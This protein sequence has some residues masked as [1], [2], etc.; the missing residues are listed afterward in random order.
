MVDYQLFARARETHAMLLA[1]FLVNVTFGVY[2]LANSG[3]R[4]Q[5]G[6]TSVSLGEVEVKCD[7]L[8]NGVNAVLKCR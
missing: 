6:V 1:L 5:Y 7:H 3:G 4:T 8:R 2:L